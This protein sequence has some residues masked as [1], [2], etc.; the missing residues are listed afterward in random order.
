[1]RPP[2]ALALVVHH[3]C[4]YTFV[5][6][7]SKRF[8]EAGL[9]RTR[10]LGQLS[11]KWLK[12]MQK[13]DQQQ[14]IL[15]AAAELAYLTGRPLFLQTAPS[16]SPGSLEPRRHDWTMIPP[17]A[18]ADW[19]KR[20]P[21]SSRTYQMPPQEVCSWAWP[22]GNQQTAQ[23]GSHLPPCGLSPRERGRGGE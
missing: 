9:L 23:G 20:R 5:K 17:P 4:H 19:S 3:V 21:N 22:E 13:T 1:M 6:A 2:K 10:L 11:T 7:L 18:A 16:L 12:N 8:E 15:P 14:K